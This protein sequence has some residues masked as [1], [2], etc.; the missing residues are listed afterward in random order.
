MS[1]L[2][3]YSRYIPI[4]ITQPFSGKYPVRLSAPE[5]IKSEIILQQDGTFHCPDAGQKGSAEDFLRMIDPYISDEGI[6][7]ALAVESKDEPE[8]GKERFQSDIKRFQTEDGGEDEFYFACKLRRADVKGSSLWF[9][10]NANRFRYAYLTHTGHPV[11]RVSW[12]TGSRRQEIVGVPRIVVPNDF[13][14]LWFVE[15]HLQAVLLRKRVEDPVLVRPTVEAMPWNDYEKIVAG[16]EII[17]IQGDDEGDYDLTS[18]PLINGVSSLAGSWRNLRY[19]PLTGGTPFAVWL[20]KNENAMEDL[21]GESKSV[22]SARTVT[23]LLY[24]DFIG[25]E[26]QQSLHFPQDTGGDMFWYG[27][28][29]GNVVHSIPVNRMT[30]DEVLKKKN[31]QVDSAELNQIQTEG[32]R[33]NNREL[34][35][36]VSSQ[37]QLTPKRVFLHLKLLI[38]RHVFLPNEHLSSLVALW[39]IG[40]YVF[41]LFQAYGYL[42]L[43]GLKDTGKTTLLSIIAECGF[44]GVL[45]SQ[46]TKASLAETVHYLSAT[47]CLDEAEEKSMSSNDEYVQLL[48]GGYRY[49]GSYTKMS[50]KRMRRLNTYSPKA[51]ASIDPLGD[52]ALDSRTITINTLAKPSKI[53]L[54]KW[55]L[56]LG[57]TKAEVTLARRGGYMMG[58]WHQKA[59]QRLYRKVSPH[60]S[61]PSGMRLENRKHQIVAPL[62]AIAQLI[63]INGSSEA[64]DSLLKALDSIWNTEYIESQKSIVLLYEQLCQWSEDHSFVEFKVENDMLYLD[65]ELFENTSIANHLGG[66]PKVLAWLNTISGVVKGGTYLKYFKNNRSCTG[67]PLDLKVHKKTVREIFSSKKGAK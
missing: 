15:N 51:I 13:K 17:C 52:E 28:V 38:E 56:S 32:I 64:E 57:D 45:Q 67:F 43:N 22:T 49:D 50:G 14:R 58:L 16:K 31:L 61:L 23:R 44:N 4:D 33:L 62:I 37:S 10:G 55:D 9:D 66:Q 30:S 12:K 60:I 7:M 25:S 48:K 1:S 46:M 21:L 35:N 27:T 24:E 59:I 3:F 65:N 5:G 54:Q 8:L 18:Y 47:I 20:A 29:E 39:V 36:I 19:S 2:L 11:C 42:R 26:S 63:D 34:I 41:K 53:T 6:K 40:G